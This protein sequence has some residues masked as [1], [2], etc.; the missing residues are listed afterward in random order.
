MAEYNLNEFGVPDKTGRKPRDGMVKG[1]EILHEFDEE[2]SPIKEYSELLKKK[3]ISGSYDDFLKE[4]A[5]L[6][7]HLERIANFMDREHGM[8]QINMSAYFV[9]LKGDDH[10][11]VQIEFPYENTVLNYRYNG[12]DFTQYFT[13]TISGDT[14]SYRQND[15]AEKYFNQL[16]E[17]IPTHQLRHMN[18]IVPKFISNYALDADPHLTVEMAFD[19]REIEKDN[20]GIY[21]D[22]FFRERKRF[23]FFPFQPVF[24]GKKN[25]TAVIILPKEQLFNVEEFRKEIA[26]RTNIDLN[27]IRLDRQYDFKIPID[28]LKYSVGLRTVRDIQ[29]NYKNPTEISDS[30]AKDFVRV[31]QQG[32]RCAQKCVASDYTKG[33]DSEGVKEGLFKRILD[34]YQNPKFADIPSAIFGPPE[35][36]TYFGDRLRSEMNR[37]F[38]EYKKR[39][40]NEV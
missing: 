22:L 21:A 24:A 34:S 9:V 10:K 40:V 30:L 38:K 28:D 13:S 8:D 39:H 36:L 7:V 14:A 12:N 11:C 26:N 23:P 5:W 29:A 27:K 18:W 25:E 17:S 1:G 37:K 4:Y 31:S 15:L 6:E 2:Y 16:M 35:D 19:I 33:K 3:R 20:S 32:I